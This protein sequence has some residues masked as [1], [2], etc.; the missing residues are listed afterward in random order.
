MI[1]Y[2]KYKNTEELKTYYSK[3]STNIYFELSI[4]SEE[5]IIL[6]INEQIIVFKTRYNN[7]LNYKCIFRKN[8]DVMKINKLLNETLL[9]KM[10]TPKEWSS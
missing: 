2:E 7:I 9:P 3:L 10:P 1:I 6:D 4:V 8:K 5:S